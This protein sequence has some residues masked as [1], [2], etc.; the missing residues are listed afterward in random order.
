MAFA[1]ILCACGSGNNT[2][3]NNNSNNSNGSSNTD[4]DTFDRS[5]GLDENGY[6]KGIKATDYVT[7]PDLST[8][9]VSKEYA[10]VSICAIAL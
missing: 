8:V 5:A 1:L 9:T 3:N 2:N 6:W 10:I 4:T 7:L